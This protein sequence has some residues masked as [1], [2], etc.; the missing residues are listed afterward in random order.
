MDEN[1]DLWRQIKAAK[2]HLFTQTAFLQKYGPVDTLSATTALPVSMTT[3]EI[4]APFTNREDTSLINLPHNINIG[5]FQE[6]SVSINTQGRQDISTWREQGSVILDA[7][8]KVETDLTER[9]QPAFSRGCSPLRDGESVHSLSAVIPIAFPRASVSPSLWEKQGAP[10]ATSD[11]LSS[12]RKQ[13]AAFQGKL[14][15]AP[16]HSLMTLQ[17]RKLHEANCYKEQEQSTLDKMSDTGSDEVMLRR[18]PRFRGNSDI[19]RP[20]PGPRQILQENTP[21]RRLSGPGKHSV[22]TGGNTNLPSHRDLGLQSGGGAAPTQRVSM[23]ADGPSQI[24]PPG[25]K[26]P[27]KAAPPATL[28]ELKK[29]QQEIVTKAHLN[30]FKDLDS[31][32]TNPEAL[33]KV[34]E[35]PGTDPKS[36]IYLEL[37]KHRD[38]PGKTSS[39]SPSAAAQSGR[40]SFDDDPEMKAKTWLER[41]RAQWT[42]YTESPSVYPV[43][44]DGRLLLLSEPTSRPALVKTSGQDFGLRMNIEGVD[45]V[46]FSDQPAEHDWGDAFYADW[47][48][49]PRACSSFEAFR[50]WFRRWLDSTILICCYVDIYHPAFFDGTA[51]PDGEQSLIIPDFDD[52]TTRLDWN[53]EESRLHYH[54]TVEGYCYNWKLQAKKEEEKEQERKVRARNA[55]IEGTKSPPVVNTPTPKA[56]IY[57]RPVESSDVTELLEIMNWYIQ[58]STL[59][60]D[61]ARLDEEEL[62]ERIET[63][64]RERLPFIVAAERRS[65]QS[66]RKTSQKLLG[67]ALVTGAAGDRTAARFTA[68]LEIFVRPEYKRRD[69][70]RCLMDKLLEVCDP[71][72]NPLG[73]YFF[74]AGW[75]DRPGYRPGGRRRLARLIFVLS[76]PFDDREQYKWVHEWLE[77]EYDFEQQGVLKG[78]RIKFSRL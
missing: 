44:E 22:Q 26:D 4:S 28:E 8:Q 23:D 11:T 59:T 29:L 67:Y 30:R 5:S 40:A 75:E 2:D 70:G 48:F 53:D 9:S 7:S 46:E 17:R 60:V 72:Y 47:E 77:N 18:A 35:G 56:N 15:R 54:E 1:Q 37:A 76:Y 13:P 52:H 19:T 38:V 39:A 64:K 31:P 68:E 25:K 6:T 61:I 50:D 14:S 21:G 71:T 33:I 55:Y 42:N 20:G 43:I 73:G 10:L 66:R 49:R 12:R 65:A 51:H 27:Y 32:S 62:R 57:L 74:D 45:E 34:R 58:R 24:R 36:E 69:V 63:S 41:C 16:F 3:G 78:A